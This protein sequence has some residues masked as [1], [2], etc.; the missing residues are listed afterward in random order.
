MKWSLKRVDNHC[1][2]DLPRNIFQEDS[3]EALKDLIKDLSDD[4]YKTFLLNFSQISKIDSKSLAY[5]I[6]IYK[7][8]DYH[9]VA[10]KLYNLQP[11][12]LQLIYQTRLNLIFDICDSNQDILFNFPKKTL[13][14]A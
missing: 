7:F 1:I 12:V 14:S 5:I 13:I 10:V 2:I 4:D 11:Y 3:I 9:E 8:A 6:N